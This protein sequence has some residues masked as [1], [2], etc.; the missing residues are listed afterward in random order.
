MKSLVSQWDCLV[1]L[2]LKKIEEHPRL[3][4]GEISRDQA[5]SYLSFY[6][7]NGGLFVDSNQ[8]ELC[9]L[10]TVHPGSKDCDW[11]WDAKSDCCTVHLCW[12]KHKEALKSLMFNGLKRF[13][14]KAV[15]YIRDGCIFH[16]TPK[17]VERLAKYGR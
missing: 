14:P 11:N 8:N 15:Y 1:D 4:N 7:L 9:G 17:K 6:G 12:A 2:F 16:L 13:L 5:E 10:M 3:W